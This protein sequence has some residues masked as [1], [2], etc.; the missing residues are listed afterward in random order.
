LVA[1]IST[2]SIISG[3]ENFV[4]FMLLDSLLRET[5]LEFAGALIL[6]GGF[7][8][9]KIRGAYVSGLTMRMTHELSGKTLET[10]PP[11]DNGGQGLSFSPTDLVAT[12][13]GSCMMSVMAIFAKRES[14]NLTGMACVV[15]KH[16]STDLPRRIARLDVVVTM[17][18]AL[19]PDQRETLES[20]GNSCPV[21]QSLSSSLHI[22]KIYRYEA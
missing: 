5:V 7:M 9:V 2:G 3:V 11:L 19:K 17:P 20:I 22:E 16:M 6:L 8:G 18:R 21:I 13:L 10:D 12:A 1:R 15:E 4:N 14:I